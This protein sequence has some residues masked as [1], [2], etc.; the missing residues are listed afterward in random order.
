MGDMAMKLDMS[1]AYDRVEWNYLCK[2]MEK[3]GFS[4]KWISLIVKCVQSVR[5]SVLV[6]GKYSD[7]S[8]PS[9]GLRQGDPLSS[10]LFLLCA[11]GLSS[12]L[13]G[14]ESEGLLKGVEVSKRGT[15]ISHLMFADD[16][17]IF[18][19]AELNQWRSLRDILNVYELVFGQQ[20]N[21]GKTSLFFS[22]NPPKLLRLSC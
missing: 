17:L 2:V 1:K 3:M 11:E 10:Y 22:T 7:T 8:V 6:N 16:C 12:M 5:Y 13:Q 4:L 21:M 19:K 18:C 15:C 9:R 20:L 14:V